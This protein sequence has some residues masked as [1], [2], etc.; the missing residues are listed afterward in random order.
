[1]F[2]MNLMYKYVDFYPD[3]YFGLLKK[4]YLHYQIQVMN[5]HFR[6]TILVLLF[7]KNLIDF[8]T[9]L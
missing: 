7:V 9:T 8:N 1:M 4:S 2:S 5:F 3:I 6:M